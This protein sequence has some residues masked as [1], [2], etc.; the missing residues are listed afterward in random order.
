MKRVLAVSVGVSFVLAIGCSDYDIRLEKTLEEKKYEKRLNTN[1]EAAPTKGKLQGDEIFVRPPL[2][3]QIAQAFVLTAAETQK[4]DI[5]NSF[6]DQKKGTSLHVVARTK[7]PK[8]P[9]S[10]KKGAAAAEQPAV[11]GKFIDDVVELVKAAYNVELAPAGLKSES[12]KH[13][14]RANDYKAVKL[15][16]TTKVVEVYVFT[17]PNGI[18]DVAMIFEYPT[19]E[20]TYM[21]PKIGLCL[22]SFAVGD[23]ARRFFDGA[24]ATDVDGGGGEMAS[25]GA[26]PPI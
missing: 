21:E 17:E 22:E 19:A 18:H 15:D 9:P 23:R 3:L 25:P 10:T 12:K 8:G 7:K 13:G 24:T 5:E 26:A 4:F 2:G 14:N 20:K 1:L 11:R 6:I 16:L